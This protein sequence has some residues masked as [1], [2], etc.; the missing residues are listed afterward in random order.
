MCACSASI[1]YLEVWNDERFAQK[2][3]ARS[4]DGRGRLE[5]VGAR[6]LTLAQGS[7]LPEA[8][9]KHPPERPRLSLRSH[10][11]DI[12]TQPVMVAEV[13]EHLEPSRGGLFIDC[14]VGLGGTRAL[15]EAGA[16]RLIGLDRDPAGGRRR[17]RAR[18]SGFGD[19]VDVVHADY[20]RLERACSTS[21]A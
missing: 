2:L 11:S 16:S 14:T 15:L 8:H 21:A 6:D 9:R 7:R 17:A 1:D 13:L 19:R 12:D 18:C 10:A 3:A 5:A 20:R 4:V